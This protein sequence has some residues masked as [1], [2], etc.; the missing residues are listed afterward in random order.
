MVPQC[1]VMS[2][3]M[4]GLEQYGHLNNS[5][6]SASC[7]VLFCDLKSKIGKKT[8]MLLLFLIRINK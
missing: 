2:V 6:P 8:Q 7:F 4:Y 3:C 5:C 1:Y